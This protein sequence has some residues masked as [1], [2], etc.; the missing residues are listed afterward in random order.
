MLQGL[1]DAPF[2]AGVL[3]AWTLAAPPGPGN[4]LIAHSA[5]RRGLLGGFVTGLGAVSAD[6]TMFLLMWIG[7]VSVLAYAPWLQVA[8]GFAGALLMARFA[9]GAWR[10]ARDPLVADREAGGGYAKAFALIVTS[11]LNWAWWATAGTTIFANV[12]FGIIA[13][14]FSGLLAW[15]VLWSALAQAGAAKVP[16]FTELLGYASALLLAG[17]AVVVGFFA[18][19]TALGMLP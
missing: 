2:L 3:L 14:F 17:F 11:P 9:W 12:G 19:R 10:S 18:A 5:A 4:A 8:L 1:S 6:A 7:V 13:G 15:I 16:R